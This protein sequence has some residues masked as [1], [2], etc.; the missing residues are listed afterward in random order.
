VLGRPG[1]DGTISTEVAIIADSPAYYHDIVTTGLPLSN[2][3]KPVPEQATS[4][5]G[6]IPKRAKNIDV[7]KDFLNISSSPE[8]VSE[9]RARAEYSMQTVNREKRPVAARPQ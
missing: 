8:R 2:D 7:A 5:C 9:S 4:A 1:A 6:L 3:G